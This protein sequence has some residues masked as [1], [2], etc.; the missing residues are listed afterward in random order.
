MKKTIAVCAILLL[1]GSVNAALTNRGTD[2][3]GNRLIYDDDLD[4]T[5]YDFS[6]PIDT[7]ANQ[8][9]WA[10]ALS[11]DF[12][13]T[14]FDDWRLPT[15]PDVGPS[16]GYDETNSEMGH[17]Y[18]TELGNV[19]NGGLGNTGDFLNLQSTNPYWSGTEDGNFT[20]YAWIFPFDTGFQRTNPKS[21]FN[22][23]LAV[24]SGDVAVIPAPG[25]LLLGMIG[26]GCVS[27]LRRRKT[28]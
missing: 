18:H 2:T 19:A 9:A 23:G 3:L 21:S 6:N 28:L 24:R 7:W 27:R 1:A 17:L 8:V 16:W 14:T 15:T 10:D 20:D 11:I 13:G 26:V 5:W 4:I 22:Y 25:A 12:G